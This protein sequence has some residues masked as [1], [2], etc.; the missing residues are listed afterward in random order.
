MTPFVWMFIKTYEK[1]REFIIQNKSISTLIQMEYSAFEEATV[2][3]CSFVLQNCKS[4]NRALCF[5]LSDFKGGMEVQREKVLEAI[6]NPDCGYFYESDQSNFS[7]IPG[8][9][10]AYWVGEKIFNL[11][12]ESETIDNYAI[13]RQGM[14]TSDNK[15][16]LR[17]WFEVAFSKVHLNAHNLDEA[18]KSQKKWFPYNKGGTFRKWSGNRDYL[19]NWENDG[20]EMKAFTATLHLGTSVRLKNQEFYFKECY[21]WSKI[22]SGNIAFRYYPSGFIFDVAGC[23]VFNAK[24][25]L[26]Y[27]L[28]LSNSKVISMLASIL[29]PT[30]NYELEQL[31]KIPVLILNANFEKINKI[32]LSNIAFSESDWDSYETSWEFKRH[33]MV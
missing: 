11:F 22:S 19:V 1:L 7:K 16:F 14:A 23:C 10:V 15:R 33:P 20:E 28:A 32:T 27:F 2:P 5:R 3:I 25:N 31:R 21:S 24:E 13:F 18:K 6:A 17:L 29:S 4:K 12:S 8:S 26:F 9:P 30:L